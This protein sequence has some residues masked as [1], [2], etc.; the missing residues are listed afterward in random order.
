MTTLE[1]PDGVDIRQTKVR[2]GVE[3][4]LSAFGVFAALE[5]RL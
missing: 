4:G 5:A 1:K 2:D 3:L